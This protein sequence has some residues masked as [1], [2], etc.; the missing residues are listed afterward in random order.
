ML[1]SSYTTTR[2]PL[3]GMSLL[4]L[5]G[6]GGL[7]AVSL[8]VG[9]E[10]KRSVGAGVAVAGPPSNAPPIVQA[11]WARHYFCRQP[12]CRR[13]AMGLCPNG[14]AGPGLA[15]AATLPPGCATCPN[16]ANCFPVP[17]AAPAAA[18]LPP[19]CA[20]CPNAANCLPGAT[21]AAAALPPGCATCP[22]AANCLPPSTGAATPAALGVAFGVPW[23]AKNPFVTL[24][25]PL[26][27]VNNCATCPQ[28]F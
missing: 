26:N 8:L 22:N 11:T 23:A 27:T 6:L 14:V 15:A 25:P 10:H 9:S 13:A 12:A 4:V 28:R 1:S 21:P 17:G 24:E 20:T 19:G 18:T 7:V 5:C 3:L 16:A 2:K